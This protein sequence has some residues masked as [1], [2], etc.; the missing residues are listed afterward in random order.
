[1]HHSWFKRHLPGDKTAG[2]AAKMPVSKSF[3]HT[4]H[5]FYLAV[6]HSLLPPPYFSPESS[7]FIKN[8]SQHRSSDSCWHLAWSYTSCA[9]ATGPST[10][11]SPTLNFRK[12]PIQSASYHAYEQCC[13]E[14]GPHAGPNSTESHQKQT[15]DKA[16][17]WAGPCEWQSW[18]SFIDSKGA[19][20]LPHSKS[21]KTSMA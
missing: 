9:R 16:V 4:F 5:E 12:C 13:G 20:I 10:T 15:A 14:K 3:L 7:M 2:H 17:V 6:Q 11:T 19:R 1:M 8:A 21:C 18:W